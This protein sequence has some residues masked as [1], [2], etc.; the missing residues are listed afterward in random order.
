MKVKLKKTERLLVVCML[1]VTIT[2]FPMTVR[3]ADNE[4]IPDDREY[5]IVNGEDIV[6]VGEDYENKDTGEYIHW[7]NRTRG[8][9]KSFSFKIRYSVTSS[10]F[11][12]H[13]SKV[14]VSAN[15]HVEDLNGNVVSGYKGHLYT[16][17][18]IGLY[19]RNLQFSVGSTQSGTISGLS[20]GGSYKV[21]IINNDYLDSNRY[22]VGSGTV[23]TT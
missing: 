7:D 19:S 5:V 9:D 6:Y 13:S 4:V 23:E 8:T 10:S 20:N 22:L 15:A 2:L 12:V 18:L 1:M 16:V 14:V 17:S 11:T 21:T 3:A